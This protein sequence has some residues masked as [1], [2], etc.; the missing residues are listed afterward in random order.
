MS[1]PARPNRGPFSRV[2]NPLAEALAQADLS[3]RE[4][5]VVWVFVRQV[6]GWKERRD[7]NRLAIG[8]GELATLTGIHRGDLRIT[9]DQLLERGILRLSDEPQN[10]PNA[11]P[12][13]YI[14]VTNPK[15]WKPVVAPK[16]ARR[17]G[18]HGTSTP[19]RPRH[20]HP[21]GVEATA[22]P[23]LEAT[24]PPPTELDAYS[25]NGLRHRKKY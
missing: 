12:T 8:R 9:I 16:R 24:A 10:A 14:F 4:H 11:A 25:P 2:P 22:P 7:T 20:L 13:D 3:A 21:G 19:W 5:R 15:A 18:G 6:L 1:G 17:G 23:P